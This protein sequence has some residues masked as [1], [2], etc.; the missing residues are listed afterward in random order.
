MKLRVTK[1]ILSLLVGL[2][3][4]VC[5]L[6]LLHGPGSV[7][8]LTDLIPWG[9]WKGGGV[10]ALVALG[11]AGF[12]VA[13]FAYIFHW[14]RYRPVVRGAVLLALLAYS[15][16]ALGLSI[17]IG[18]PWRIVFPVW[19]WQLHSV[20]FEVAWCIMLYLG[21]L[22]LEFAPALLEKL[23]WKHALG[24]V[25]K[26]TIVF[27][28]AGI[29][30]STLHQSSLG[31]LFLATPFRLHPLW[32]T[33]LL[34]VLFFVSSM[35]V[36]CLTI[37]LVTLLVYWLHDAAP[38]MVALAGLGRIAAWLLGAYL[39]LRFLEIGLAG[40]SEL[41]LR[42]DADTLSFWIE[43]LLSAG[44]PLALLA[45]P[46]LRNKPVALGLIAAC[47]ASGFT[48]NRVEVAGLATLSLTGTSYWPAWTEWAITFGLLS[49]AALVYL[50]AVER[51]E[52]F[53]DL[54]G[55]KRQRAS[56]PATPDP[57]DWSS[58]FFAGQRRGGVRLY[59]FAFVLG[60]A[61][62]LGAVSD[63]ELYGVQPRAVPVE[64]P[65]RVP[66]QR[67]VDTEHAKEPAPATIG[68]PVWPLKETHVLLI[69][70]GRDGRHVLFDHE[71][72]V[73]MGAGGGARCAACHH[74]NRPSE[75]ATGCSECHR[76]MYEPTDIFDHRLHTK[77][78]GGNP[79]CVRCHGD[80][81]EPK[82]R[83]TA[84]PCKD[85][86]EE[87]VRRRDTLVPVD[88][89]RPSDLAVGYMDALHGLCVPCH[90]RQGARQS[91]RPPLAG[92]TNCHRAPVPA[93]ER[94]AARLRGLR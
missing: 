50:L 11:G 79:G 33:D 68:E 60:A 3:V 64:R 53:P 40:E 28:I 75:R 18:I 34:P 61:L 46:R 12:T 41:L 15:S 55:A 26:A 7:T 76:D 52:I 90:E 88:P 72:H 45:R 91:R 23:G 49:G 69:D 92:C 38:P 29:S 39:V 70:G 59:S 31:T 20:L 89:D 4:V 6:R 67:R 36:G 47:A 66:A 80:P 71:R 5:I 85:C 24:A 25:H 35:A 1:T 16:V 37:S 14:N 42:A 57:R 94:G 83:A 81:R 77:R 62:A 32:Y 9:L 17:D 54:E 74:L 10:V 30:L 51:L 21:M 63:T 82:T 73:A 65:R 13:M 48:L 43:T 86:H 27:V 58:A 8:A 87:Q 44:L 56:A 22:A 84:R 2:S 93:L 78:L 19:H